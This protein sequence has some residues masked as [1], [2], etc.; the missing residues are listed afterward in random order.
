MWS[1]QRYLNDEKHPVIQL[2]LA[3]GLACKVLCQ[4]LMLAMVIAVAY[5][6]KFD[7][8]ALASC[9]AAS[10]IVVAIMVIAIGKTRA[11]YISSLAS[12]DLALA[13]VPDHAG[14]EAKRLSKAIAPLR[15]VHAFLFTGRLYREEMPPASA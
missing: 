4:L 1:C 10:G 6:M 15:V 9:T 13:T 12:E 14:A 2:Q 8:A 7:A 11:F 3:I 5:K